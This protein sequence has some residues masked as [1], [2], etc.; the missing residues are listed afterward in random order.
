MCSSRVESRMIVY[1]FNLILGLAHRG[2]LAI[3]K[4]TVRQMNSILKRFLFV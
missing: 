1:I 3:I 4:S 2:I